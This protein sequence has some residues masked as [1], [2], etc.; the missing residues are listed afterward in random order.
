[1]LPVGLQVGGFL[2]IRNTNVTLLPAD[3]K[4]GGTIYG[5]TGDKSQVPLHLRNKLK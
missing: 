1:L 3:L 5:F 4:V 2:D